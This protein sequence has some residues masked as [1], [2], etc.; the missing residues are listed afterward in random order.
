MAVDPLV[1][2]AQ[3]RLAM[4]RRALVEQLNG[5][6]VEEEEAAPYRPRLKSSHS[7]GLNGAVWLPVAR[8]VVK[9]WWQNHPANAVGHL[10]LPALERYARQ[11]PV[12]VVAAAAAVGALIVL[13]RPWRL[14]S[15]TAVLATILKTS[16]VAGV[17]TTLM[18]RESPP[19]KDP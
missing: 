2:T 3:Q 11:E 10:A 4:S 7:P 19:R 9:R 1:L 5:G 16:D 14:I 18:H 8:K 17:V 6:V 12:K 15:I 13:V